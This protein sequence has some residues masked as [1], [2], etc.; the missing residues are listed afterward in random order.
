VE[1]KGEDSD[2]ILE[3]NEIYEGQSCGVLVHAGAG[4]VVR[5][6]LV[7]SNQKEG[8]RQKDP[9]IVGRNWQLDPRGLAFDCSLGPASHAPFSTY[10]SV[11]FVSFFVLR[12]SFPFLFIGVICLAS[13]FIYS[14]TCLGLA[15]LVLFFFQNLSSASVHS[16]KGCCVYVWEAV[17]RWLFYAR[18]ILHQPIHLLE[19]RLTTDPAT[20]FAS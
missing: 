2:P 19:P 13:V 16:M 15:W 1:I 20:L 4:G 10:V 18:P 8:I 5:R 3:D 9:K 14:H 12:L 6:N 17:C 11:S 7:H